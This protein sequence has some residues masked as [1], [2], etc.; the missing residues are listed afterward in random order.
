MRE[1][2]RSIS[3][4][5]GLGGEYA[6]MLLHAPG[7]H[8]GYM[9][10]VYGGTFRLFDKVLKRFG[11][12]FTP[13]DAGDI[14]AV[15]RAMTSKTRMLWLESPTNPLPRIVD[16]HAVNEIAHRQGPLVCVANPFATPYLQPPPH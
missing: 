8:V 10:D 9:E 5:S 16:I 1:A 2:K 14:D 13:V 6:L 15:E 3:F 11:M 4:T 12:T 7:D